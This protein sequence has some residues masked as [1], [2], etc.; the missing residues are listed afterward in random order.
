[1]VAGGFRN[2]MAVAMGPRN[3]ASALK[4]LKLAGIGDFTK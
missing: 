1:V 4:S 2:G 3:E